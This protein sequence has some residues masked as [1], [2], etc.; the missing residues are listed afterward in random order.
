VFE[1][2]R[3]ARP[4]KLY[5]AADGPRPQWVGEAEACEQ[6]RN[7][8]EI[9]DWPCEVHRLYR[10]ENV[11]CRSGISEAISWFLGE[12]GEG[13]ILE[14][15][16]LPTREFFEFSAKLLERYRHDERVM[17]I[18]GSNFHAG[19][20]W[21]SHGYYFSRYNH[22]WGWATWKRA[23]DQFNLDLSGLEEFLQVARRT[24][25]WDSKKEGRYWGKTLRQARDLVVDAWDYQWNYAMWSRGGLCVYP[26]VN[27]ISNIGF[28]VGA[29][30]TTE[31][32][33]GKG[34][35]ATGV[36]ED[37]THPRFLVRH[38]P[39]D[40]SNFMKMFWGNPLQRFLG[41]AKRVV[42]MLRTSR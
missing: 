31:A 11:G 39:A 40:Q 2:I 18:N 21:S 32:G 4:A 24:G 35:L 17:H 9:V 14:D 29:T 41:R 33:K 6:A 3:S 30:N 22:G 13:V 1:A 5:I 23:W 25:F 8:V 28:G 7:A 36:Q 15:D 26:E 16:C 27:M 19:K 20:R 34:F 42:T 12:V 37:W 10:E 38:R